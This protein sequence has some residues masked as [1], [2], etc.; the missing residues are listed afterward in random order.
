MIILKKSLRAKRKENFY[1]VQSFLFKK[2]L[3]VTKMSF[4]IYFCVGH[5]NGVNVIGLSLQQTVPTIPA[6]SLKPPLL[7]QSSLEFSSL[8][9]SQLQP[10]RPTT[11]NVDF[12][13]PLQPELLLPG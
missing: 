1:K 13:L 7:H 8:Q 10:R 5:V 6:P 4:F 9:V 11:G 3:S 2:Y 12:L